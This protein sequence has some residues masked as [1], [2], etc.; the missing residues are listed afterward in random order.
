VLLA[1]GVPP[2]ICRQL[3]P[4]QTAPVANRAPRRRPS[5]RRLGNFGAPCQ[6]RTDDLRFTRAVLDQLSEGGGAQ[7]ERPRLHDSS[8]SASTAT[9]P[10]RRA[11]QLEAKGPPPRRATQLEA[12][13]PTPEASAASARATQPLISPAALRISVARACESLVFSVFSPLMSTHGVASTPLSRAFW[14]DCSTNFSKVFSLTQ[15]STVCSGSALRAFE[16]S[17]P[18]SSATLSSSASVRPS[19]PSSGCW[20]KRASNRSTATSGWLSTTQAARLADRV[21]YSL[22]LD[23]RSRNETGL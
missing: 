16:V 5:S 15:D 23:M 17:T 18:A 14:L 7:T 19:P 8:P 9:K 2:Q 3:G 12:E 21:E 11:T 6:T 22:P 1:S 10:P 20:A 13:R 4:R